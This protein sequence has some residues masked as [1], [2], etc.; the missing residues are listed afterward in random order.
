MERIFYDINELYLGKIIKVKGYVENKSNLLNGRPFIEGKIQKDGNNNIFVKE[1]EL[2]KNVVSDKSY[3]VLKYP[4]EVGAVGLQQ[5][6]MR[7]LTER[8][9]LALKV[10]HIKE[11]TLNINQIATL[12]N[13][14][15]LVHSENEMDYAYIFGKFIEYMNENQEEKE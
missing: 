7:P 2:F 12:Q 4:C 8:L 15:A 6:T 14:L 11:M 10:H 3:K 9:K 5:Y 13:M 1:G